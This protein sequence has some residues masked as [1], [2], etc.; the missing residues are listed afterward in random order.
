MNFVTFAYL[1]FLVACFAAYYVLPKVARP[2]VL[3]AASYVFYLYDPQN[4]GFVVLL[5]TMTLVTYV[6]GLALQFLPAKNLL[7]R[8]LVLAAAAFICFA[9]LLYYK[10]AGFLLGIVG[11]KQ[12]WSIAQ[13]LGISFFLL[14]AIGYLID[15]YRGK[16]RAETNVLY[17]A[18]FV[19]FFPCIMAGPITRG[20]K[21]LPQF[22]APVTFSYARV[23]GG[24]FRVLW[25][26]FKKLV[27]SNALYDMLE[28][29]IGKMS[30]YPGPVLLLAAL[31]F[32]YYLYCDFAA[33]SD[34]A[35]G[36]ASIFGIEVAENFTRPFGSSTY[37][38]MWKRWHIGLSSWFR[39]YLYFPLG[40]N[41]KGRM[42]ANL[43]QIIV[44]SVS[45]L[46]HGASFGYIVWG[47]FNGLA[48][49]VGKET[50]P[51]RKKLWRY[52]PLYRFRT[53]RQICQAAFTYVLFSACFVLF[54]T[55]LFGAQGRGMQD[56]AYLFSHIFTNW[57][58]AATA[59]ALTNLG[60][61]GIA[62]WVLFGSIVL[63]EC[64]E[65]PRIPMHTLIRRIPVILRWPLYYALLIT[66]FF[67][68]KFGVSAFVYQAY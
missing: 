30:S 18:L 34:I 38:E 26:V 65:F 22:K 8:R 48:L 37:S 2:F 10:Y 64:M 25:G 60:W 50:A 54:C 59:K 57:D 49:V 32:S 4:A 67:F 16:Y 44:F 21:M 35:I 24:A 23:S 6:A 33:L 27:I 62:G 20:G 12:S 13:P 56:A 11:V 63:V 7:P 17:Y 31:G 68:G 36:S 45:G 39:D 1:V 19:S 52:N 3:L 5:I 41:R 28:A 42:R 46:W 14:Q 58:F 9:A 40:G 55:E 66:M 29:V 53:A 43:N 47:F 61:E 15:V 51:Y